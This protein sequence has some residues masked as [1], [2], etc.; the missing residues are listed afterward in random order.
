MDSTGFHVA[1]K[2]FTNLTPEEGVGISELR[3]QYPYSQILQLLYAKV[4]RDL[5]HDDQEDALHEAAVYATDRTVLKAVMTASRTE[6]TYEIPE[7]V[8]SVEPPVMVVVITEKKPVR[9]TQEEE[10]FPPDFKDTLIKTI[11]IPPTDEITLSGDALRDDLMHELEKLQK[12]KHNF[13]VSVNEFEKSTHS[14]RNG[15]QRIV[16]EPVVEPLLEEIKTTKK[17]LKA[18]TPRQLEQNEIIDQFIKTQPILPKAKPTAPADD[19]SEDSGMF[20]DNI[21]SETLVE[22][23]LKQ[24]K[25]EKAI[26]VLKKLIWKFPQKKAYFAAQIENLKN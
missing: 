6:R 24:G 19:L 15:S 13:E 10:I 26:E 12:L 16:R 2:N 17:K 25:K 8:K 3:N 14:A 5:R 21:V 18:D 7:S 22:I 4:A 23:L 11:G 9:M 1:V 20:S